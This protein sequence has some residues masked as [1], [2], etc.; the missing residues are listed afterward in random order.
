MTGLGETLFRLN[1]FVTHETE[2]ER[3]ITQLFVRFDATTRSLTY[4]NAGHPDG[5]V[6]DYRG[7]L[8]SRLRSN[9]LPLGLIENQE[10]DILKPLPLEPGDIVLLLTDGI[11]EA[12]S[13][14]GEIFGWHRVFAVMQESCEKSAAE[15]CQDLIDIASAFCCGA[16][17]ADDRTA[18]VVKVAR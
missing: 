15:S 1:D 14:H 6:L 2:T 16:E 4:I 12:A 11:L 3:F 8:K 13:V 10:Y 9:G 18:L 5:L 17:V 7:Q